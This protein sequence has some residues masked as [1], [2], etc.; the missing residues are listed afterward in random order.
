MKTVEIRDHVGRHIE[1]G[2]ILDDE[3]ELASEVIDFLAITG[4]VGTSLLVAQL[5]PP[6]PVRHPA[7]G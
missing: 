1:L 2:Q 7:G 4:E 3:V 5:R 6:G